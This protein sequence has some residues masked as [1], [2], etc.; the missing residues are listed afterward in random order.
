MH[1]RLRT[2]TVLTALLLIAPAARALEPRG[3]AQAGSANGGKRLALVIGNQSYKPGMALKNSVN[4]A[5][6]MYKALKSLDFDVK[7]VKDATKKEM[8]EAVAHFAGGLHPG[9]VALFYYAG[10]G[11]QDAG[12]NYLIP[13]DFQARNV[14]DARDSSVQAGGIQA[15]M[16]SSNARLKIIILDACRDNPFIGQR[17]IQRGLAVMSGSK[18]SCI[19]FATSPG[20]TASDNPEG[21]NGLFTGYLIKALSIPGLTLDD[22]FNQVKTG[23][24][25]ESSGGQTPW[26]LSSAVGSSFIFNPEIDLKPA[27]TTLDPQPMDCQP[28][29]ECVITVSGSWVRAEN[30]KDL[31]LEVLGQPNPTTGHQDY[32]VQST[33]IVNKDGQW[34][35]SPV[36]IGQPGDRKGMPFKICVVATQRILKEGVRMQQLPAGIQSCL[37]VTRSRP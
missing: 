23:V 3:S 10:H 2:L 6:G 34:T 31:H 19:V 28:N 11:F 25:K 37:V 30:R 18:G 12:E 33:P 17:G 8:D 15:R 14:T 21:M 22:V 29:E 9:D 4:D 26:V 24:D 27:I 20:A 1:L 36:Y 16:E 7:L 32:W 13:I 35:S 5:E